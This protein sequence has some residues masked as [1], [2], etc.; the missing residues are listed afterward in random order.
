MGKNPKVKRT[1][2]RRIML[3]SKC[4]I[5]DSK[6]LKFY[7]EQEASGLLRSLRIKTLLNKIRLLE[8]PVLRVFHKLIKIK[9]E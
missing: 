6:K 4:E 5:C 7:K 9:N 1:K 8:P 2:N 3:L